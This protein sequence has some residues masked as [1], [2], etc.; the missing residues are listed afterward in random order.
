[1]A[2][3][4]FNIDFS[5]MNNVFGTAMSRLSDLQQL[6]DALGEQLVSSTIERFENETGPDGEKWKPSRRAEDE[7]GQTLSDT[8]LLKNSINYEASPS[9]VVV[10]TTDS[11]KGA[12]HQFGGTIKPKQANALKF[13]TPNGFVTV[14]QVKM[15]A[16]PYIGINN[17][18]IKEAKAAIAL[19]MR[20]GFGGYRGK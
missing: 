13:E 15:P 14:K 18:D 7:G 20:R 4:S 10:G 19:F 6:S 9:A 16:R 17:E 5:K 2:G 8:G 11:V 1:M 12:I 3:A